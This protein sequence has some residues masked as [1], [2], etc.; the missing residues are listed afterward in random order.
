MQ[1]ELTFIG[2]IE[3]PYK[4][5][6]DC[7]RNID[8]NGPLCRLV[9]KNPYGEGLLGLEAG[10]EILILYWLEHADRARLRQ[11][12][13]HIGKLT[14]TFAL[15][16]PHRPSPIGAALVKIEAISGNSITVKG[17]DCLD[18]TPLIDIKPA[19]RSEIGRRV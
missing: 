17:L 2:H 6:G 1:A 18:G 4:S 7:P 14:G 5:L 10:R 9:L 16:S 19:M 8:P 13:A 15:R 12:P 3:T 11:N